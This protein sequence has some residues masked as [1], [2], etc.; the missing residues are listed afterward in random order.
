[1]TLTGAIRFDTFKNSYPDQVLGPAPLAPT[2]N[3]TLPG[4]PNLNWKDL[5]FR[6]GWS[7][8]VFGD[9]KTAIKVGYN[10]FLAGQALGGLGSNTNPVGRLVLSAN[11]S[12]TDANR[13]FVPE[14]NLTLPAAN[15]ECGA[16][17]NANFGTNVASEIRDR[18]LR[19]GWGKRSYNYEFSAGVQREL[20]PRVSADVGFFRRWYG[21]FTATDDVNLTPAMLDSFSMVAPT[22]ARLGD[23]SGATITGLFNRKPEFFS[24]PEN[25]RIQLAKN[26]GDQTEVW[27]GFDVNMQARLQNGLMLQGGIGTGTT[28]TDSCEIR[29]ALPESALLNPYCHVETPWL[30]QVKGVG[31]YTI[32]RV[33][34]QIAGT[35]QSIPG[36]ARSANY[37]LTSAEA[38]RSLGRPLAGNA[39]N[40]TV[41]LL[42]GGLLYSERI[43]QL[44]LR[45]GKIVRFGRTRTNV[46][47]DVFNALNVDT[48]TGEN[49]S[50]ATLWRPTSVLQSRFFKVS[51]QVEF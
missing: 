18:D 44:D 38:A 37:T 45:F 46:S 42:P 26:F 48:I 23:Q 33:D 2:R 9:G 29:A 27:Q 39:A 15:G 6:S 22:D 24:T 28:T 13:N 19:E 1:M 31:V 11:R 7:Y 40:V 17:S 4:E 30:T 49:S 36:D 35:F 50:Y 34:V 5:S 12:W 20:M 41:N 10:K 43:N 3:F 8:D 16:L 14:C 21:N 47:L 51:A 25:N 32:P